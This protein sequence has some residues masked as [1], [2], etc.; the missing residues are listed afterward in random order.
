MKTILAITRKE[1]AIYFGSPLALIFIGAFLAASLFTFFWVDAFFARGI[2]DMRPLFRWM[3]VLLIFLVATLTMRQWSEEQRSGTLELLL[4]LP[5]QI[6]RLVLGKFLAVVALVALALALTLPLA[7]SVSMLG[8]LDWGPVIGGYLAALLLAS[9]YAAIGLFSSS[10]TDN[11]V[12]A[13]IMTA[14]IGGALYLIGSGGVTDFVGGNLAEILRGIGTGSRFESIERG[15]ID[16]RDLIYYAALTTLFLALTIISLDRKRWST[17][18]RLANYRRNMNLTG[19]LLAANLIALNIWV[20]PLQTLRLDLTE[21]GEFSLSQATR[22]LLSTLQ[23]PLLIR[24]YLSEKTHPLLAP[25][26]PRIRDLLT[27]YRI[28]GNGRVTA[29]VVDP[30]RDPDVEAEAGRVYG[31]QPTPLQV[32]GRYEASVINAYFDILVRYGDQNTVLGFRDLIEVEGR[33]DGSVDVRLRNLEY[34]LTRAIKKVA[35]GFQSIDSVFASLKEP[36]NLMLIVTPNTLPS[37]YAEVPSIVEKV[38]KEVQAR[39]GSKFTYQVID[40]DAP[41]APLNRAVLRERYQVQPTP[42]SFFS[43]E[44]FYLNLLLTIDGQTQ[45]L[46]PEGS[47][48]EATVRT[49]IES[50][51]KRS[52][53]GFLRVVGLWTPP[54][55]PDPFGQQT[56][57]TTQLISEQLRREYTV[58]SVDLTSGQVPPDIDVL[59]LIGPRNLSERERYAIDQYLMRGGSIVVAAGTYKLQLQSFGPPMLMPVQDGIADL[60]EHYGIKIVNGLVMDPQNEPFPNEVNRNVGGL[61]VRE[62]QALP[63]PFFVDVRADGMDRSNPIVSQLPAVTLQWASPIEI[64]PAKNSGRKVSALLRSTAQAWLRTDPNIQ[65]DFA[66]HPEYGFSVEADRKPFTIAVAIQGVFESFYKGKPSPLLAPQPTPQAGSSAEAT[67]TPEPGRPASTLESSPETARLV[68]IGSNEFVND[69][70]LQLSSRL[71]PERYLNNLQFAQNAVDWSV[72]DL[73]LL[74][75]RARG[76]STRV[77][78]PLTEN[79]RTAWEVGNYAVALLALVG[80]GVVWRTRQRGEKPMLLSG[81]TTA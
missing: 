26:I 39:A 43:T 57:S 58:R 65:P 2:A 10:R 9:A 20:A 34:D 81:E 24:A 8:D 76:T 54:Q 53:G 45:A 17:G 52:A 5:A 23:E 1:L 46:F 64:D 14:L 40:P 51:L 48:N 13:L 50:A 74:T 68:V 22:D 73:D 37:V 15:V 67:P 70:I 78:R 11:Q 56:Q 41:N 25:L 59:M 61:L 49:A 6:S 79:Q 35:F 19:A 31:I 44:T 21:Q 42:V 71:S 30:A 38:A 7:L 72:E 33:R 32:S 16:L 63:Y 55:T 47:F 66:A 80:L 28:A 60:L 36:A 18:P 4:T 27:E 77:L 29:E 75:I 62:I 69:L 3:P 12:V